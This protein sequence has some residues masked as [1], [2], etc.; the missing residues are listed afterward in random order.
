MKLFIKFNNVE[1]IF[2]QGDTEQSANKIWFSDDGNVPGNHYPHMASEY[3]NAASVQT[4]EIKCLIVFP[5]VQELGT[6]KPGLFQ[7]MDYVASQTPLSK[8]IPGKNTEGLLFL[9]SINYSQ[10]IINS[11]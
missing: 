6:V 3:C 1:L 2:K 7:P 5:Q 11:T 4:E 8:W 10:H 9:F